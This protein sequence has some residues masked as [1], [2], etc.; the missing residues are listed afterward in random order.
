MAAQQ[1]LVWY[2]VDVPKALFQAGLILVIWIWRFFSVGFFIPRIFSPWH[3]DIT[4]YGTGFDLKIWLHAF[5]WNLISRFIGAIL[6]LFFILTGL[7]LE[8][9]AVLDLALM[10][11]CWYLSVTII[12]FLFISGFKGL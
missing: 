9:L 8:A 1:F 7:S 5:S 11:A 4:G 10:L 12:A 3:K 6:R 2:F